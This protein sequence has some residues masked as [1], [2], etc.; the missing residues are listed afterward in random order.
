MRKIPDLN[1]STEDNHV[2]GTSNFRKIEVNL[3]ILK[4]ACQGVTVE[5]IETCC[6]HNGDNKFTEWLGSLCHRTPPPNTILLK[7]QP[8]PSPYYAK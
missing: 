2:N 3:Q 5:Q 8:R 6:A 7:R 1:E 4:F